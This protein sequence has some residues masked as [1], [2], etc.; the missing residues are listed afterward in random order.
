MNANEK[1]AVIMLGHGSRVAGAG[2]NMEKIARRLKEVYNFRTIEFCF[3]SRLGPH[4]P[5]T[6]QRVVA[7]GETNIMVLPYFLHSGVHILLDIPEMMQ[8]E[9]KKY[10]G[11]KLTFGENLGYDDMLVELL[12]K[13]IEQSRDYKDVRELV[14]PGKDAF[15]LPPGEKEFV[16][17]DPEEA[18]KHRLP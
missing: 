8:Q 10:P 18:K 12:Y 16:P 14:L 3:M 15:P 17:M 5:E 13:R 4:F 2:E 9:A 11:I 6:L 7:A 1:P